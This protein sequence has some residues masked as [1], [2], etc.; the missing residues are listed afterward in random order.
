MPSKEFRSSSLSL[1]RTESQRGCKMSSLRN[2]RLTLDKNMVCPPLNN[3]SIVHR[4]CV[5][6][7]ISSNQSCL[8]H[9]CTFRA[10]CPNK[11]YS[12]STGLSS[13]GGCVT[14]A[15]AWVTC[16]APVIFLCHRGHCDSEHLPKFEADFNPVMVTKFIW[17]HF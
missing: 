1:R 10:A 11:S 17:N 3:L 5:C 7:S 14:N 4:T 15:R 6:T 2:F 16:T 8:L 13:W 12:M 9:Q